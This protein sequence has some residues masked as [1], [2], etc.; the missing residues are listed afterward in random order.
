MLLPILPHSANRLTSYQWTPA[1]C[2]PWR[3]R[4]PCLAEELRASGPDCFKGSHSAIQ[5][6]VVR[7]SMPP[8]QIVALLHAVGATIPGVPQVELRPFYVQQPLGRA[9]LSEGLLAALGALPHI[10]PGLELLFSV[11]PACGGGFAL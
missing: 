3:P 8:E 5:E 7:Y 4:K 6:G 1:R 9:W 11:M 10:S 2:V